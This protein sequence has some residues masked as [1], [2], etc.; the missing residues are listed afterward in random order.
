MNEPDF[1]KGNYDT[2]FI[3]KNSESLFPES[4][5]KDITIRDLAAITA[6]LH[7]YKRL[8]QIRKL[9]IVEK[10]HDYW[11]NYGRRKNSIRI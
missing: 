6:Y 2:H 11:R 1:V 3:Q 8:E 10:S 4:S 5:K 7:H 9:S